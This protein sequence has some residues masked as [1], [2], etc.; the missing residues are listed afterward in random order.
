MMFDFL[1][2]NF[3]FKFGERVFQKTFAIHT[4]I[5]YNPFLDDLFL[6]QCEAGFIEKLI[7]KNKNGKYFLKIYSINN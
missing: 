3:F 7:W 6:Y 2:E 4:G 5:N 1:I